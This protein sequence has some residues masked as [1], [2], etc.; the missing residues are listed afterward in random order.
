MAFCVHGLVDGANDILVSTGCVGNVFQVFSH[1]FA[2][3]GDAIAV[4]QAGLQQN[5]HHLWDATGAVQVHGQ[6]LTAGFQVANDGDLLA[7]ALEVVDGPLHTCG[8]GYGQ[9]V[10]HSIG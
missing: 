7:H 10:Q 8:V 2:S 6:V 4:Q 9:E 3:D 1:C 5:L